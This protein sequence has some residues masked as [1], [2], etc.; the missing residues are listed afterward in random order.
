MLVICVVTWGRI[1]K[2][3]LQGSIVGSVSSRAQEGQCM[4]RRRELQGN[5]KRTSQN[6]IWG[7]SIFVT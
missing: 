3:R 1:G 6:R 2:A 5:A 7:V 4:E